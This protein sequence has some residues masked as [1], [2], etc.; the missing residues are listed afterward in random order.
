MDEDVIYS[1]NR[2]ALAD[3]VRHYLFRHI[4]TRMK[5]SV[6]SKL[7]QVNP[8]LLA[9]YTISELGAKISPYLTS[10]QRRL[11]SILK[12]V[13]SQKNNVILIDEPEV[14][15][16]ID[17]QREIVDLIRKV[18]VSDFLS[19]LHIPP[20]VIYHHHDDVI[21]LGADILG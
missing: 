12:N 20:D 5:C 11:Y 21:D 13:D 16:H 18:S 7:F 3:F 15:L 8:N 6:L 9:L 14:S 2:E 1:K 4:D 17:W 10:G 19:Y